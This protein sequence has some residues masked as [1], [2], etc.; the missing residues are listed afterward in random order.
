MRLK[1]NLR[2]QNKHNKGGWVYLVLL[3]IFVSS[4]LLNSYI[5]FFKPTHEDVFLTFRYVEHIKKTSLPLFYDEFSY[6]GRSVEEPFLFYYLLAIFSQLH[7]VFVKIIPALLIASLSILVFLISTEFVEKKIALLPTLGAAFVPVLFKVNIISPL[8]L[9]LFLLFL[10]IYSFPR[11]EDKRFLYLFIISSVLLPLTSPISIFFIFS[12]LVYL[13]VVRVERKKISVLETEALLFS[14]FVNILLTILIF[15]NSFITYG[16]S[17]IWQNIPSSILAEYFKEFSLLNTLNDIGAAILLFGAFGF[18]YSF[19]EKNT[20]FLSSILISSLI[21]LWFKLLP[22]NIG[23]IIFSLTLSALSALSFRSVFLRIRESKISNFSEHIFIV[24]IA[25]VILS[26][27]VPAFFTAMQFESKVSPETLKA[28][29]S[30]S[31]KNATIAAPYEYGHVITFFQNKNVADALFLLAPDP[32]NRLEDIKLI[33]TSQSETVALDLLRKY[34]TKILIFDEFAQ[35]GFGI[36][37]LEYINKE[38][39]SKLYG[40]NETKIYNIK[41]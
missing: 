36:E 32:E 7:E 31:V 21:F 41:C 20:I 9:A 1:A 24:L 38:C 5:L 3:V 40:E 39:F 23:L 11:I 22:F 10:L 13:A 30:I 19:K 35:K 6:G 2:N 33:Y 27:T 34:N 29:E 18:F 17:F 8:A 14:L 16:I 37:N 26:S 4:F 25:M 12:L 28:L 15:R